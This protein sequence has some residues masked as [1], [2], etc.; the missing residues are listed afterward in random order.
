M[1]FLGGSAS[2]ATMAI[3]QD[4]DGD[5]NRAGYS[6]FPVGVG[7]AD[8]PGS[9]ITAPSMGGFTLRCINPDGSAGKVT[10]LG[11]LE[12]K[13]SA[14]PVGYDAVIQI[15]SADTLSDTS[16]ITFDFIGDDGQ[17]VIGTQNEV[18]PTVNNDRSNAIVRV[19][20]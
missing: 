11:E 6:S 8:K 14:H 7:C 13:H 18:A 15:P 17:A 12:R 5:I 9:I 10:A 20:N 16:I 1:V 4:R 2:F 3:T 19:S